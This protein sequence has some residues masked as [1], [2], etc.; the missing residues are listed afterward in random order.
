MPV[1]SL[2]WT[3]LTPSK[4]YSTGSSRVTRLT[5]SVLSLPIMVYME[6]DL[7]EPVGPTMRITPLE[8]SSRALNFCRFLP[9]RPMPLV[10]SRELD[11]LSSRI[12][13]F[14]P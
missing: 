13:T 14:S 5:C 3:W 9:T 12:T 10:F 7:P 1:F 6:E 8:F 4:L 2:I 11:L